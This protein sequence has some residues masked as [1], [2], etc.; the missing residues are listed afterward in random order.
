MSQQSDVLFLYLVLLMR[1]FETKLAKG[2]FSSAYTESYILFLNF[3]A[4]Q[5]PC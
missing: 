5:V 1:W 3:F 2:Q 4:A